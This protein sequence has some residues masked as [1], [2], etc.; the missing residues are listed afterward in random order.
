[1]SLVASTQMEDL[2]QRLKAIEEKLLAIKE[3]L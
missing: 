3:Y 2:T 1:M